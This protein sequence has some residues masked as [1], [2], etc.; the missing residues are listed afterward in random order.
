[1]AELH[2]IVATVLTAQPLNLFLGTAFVL[3]VAALVWAI[4]TPR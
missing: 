2:A 3:A 1:M 4:R